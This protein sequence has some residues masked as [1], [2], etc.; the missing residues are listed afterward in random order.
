[1]EAAGPDQQRPAERALEPPGE[2]VRAPGRQQRHRDAGLTAETARHLDRPAARTTPLDLVGQG[3]DDRAAVQRF[4]IGLIDQR[5]QR[6][7]IGVPIAG[8]P[9]EGRHQSHFLVREAVE[10]GPG[11]TTAVAPGRPHRVDVVSETSATFLV[12]QGIGQYDY[13]ALSRGSDPVE[14]ETDSA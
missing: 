2:V 6:P 8:L 14:H 11:E 5:A 3:E 9:D 13:V 7:G 1:M 4:A 10:L 12:L